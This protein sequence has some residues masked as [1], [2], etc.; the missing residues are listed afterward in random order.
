M[1]GLNKSSLLCRLAIFQ[2]TDDLSDFAASSAPRAPL[3][4]KRDPSN[5]Y[6]TNNPVSEIFLRAQLFHAKRARTQ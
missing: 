5:F 2:G 3:S 4:W 6:M 1:I